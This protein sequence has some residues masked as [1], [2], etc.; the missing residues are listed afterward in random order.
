MSTAAYDMSILGCTINVSGNSLVLDEGSVLAGHGATLAVGSGFAISNGPVHIF[1]D[2][3]DAVVR[4]YVLRTQTSDNEVAPFRLDWP[5][6]LSGLPL[7]EEHTYLFNATIVGKTQGSN[8]PFDCAA[9]KIQGLIVDDALGIEVVDPYTIT[10]IHRISSSIGVSATGLLQGDSELLQINVTGVSGKDINWVAGVDVV[11]LGGVTTNTFGRGRS[12]T[13]T[14]NNYHLSDF[15]IIVRQPN[16]FVEESPS[17]P[18]FFCSG[19]T[20]SGDVTYQWEYRYN[21]GSD[22]ETEF[23]TIVGATGLSYEPPESATALLFIPTSSPNGHSTAYPNE[24]RCIV[25]STN[26]ES[27]T[28]RPVT[29][30]HGS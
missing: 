29:W 1:G 30:M 19:I 17:D 8:I 24:F 13:Y 18:S 10:N 4:K 14:Y 21:G 12:T 20:N 6:G 26:G 23:K 11:E 7:R 2:D 16:N 22:E 28:S 27:A 15:C 9:F 3:D 25:S 5:N